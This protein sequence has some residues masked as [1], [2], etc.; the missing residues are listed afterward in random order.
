M[1]RTVI[2]WLVAAAMAGGRF[3]VPGHALSWPG[4]YEAFAHLWIGTMCGAW[5]FD[6][7]VQAIPFT[8]FRKSKYLWAVGLTTVLEVVMFALR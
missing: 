3:L 4:T 8:V 7:E 5:W 6:R 2:F 1:N